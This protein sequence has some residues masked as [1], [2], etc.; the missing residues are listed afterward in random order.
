MAKDPFLDPR[1]AP[2][3]QTTASAAPEVNDG[4]MPDPA[5][6]KDIRDYYNSVMQEPVPQ[7]FLDLLAK[8]ASDSSE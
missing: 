7:E 5:W 6:S 8:I 2:K 1:I 3:G 4:S